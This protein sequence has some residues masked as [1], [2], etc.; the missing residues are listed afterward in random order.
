ME[1]AFNVVQTFPQ[2][3]GIIYTVAPYL[4]HIMVIETNAIIANRMS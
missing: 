2:V 4:L 3:P 1:S